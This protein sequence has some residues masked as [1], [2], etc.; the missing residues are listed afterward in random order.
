[1]LD[2]PKFVIVARFSNRTPMTALSDNQLSGVIRIGQLSQ[3]C[4]S[5]SQFAE[6]MTHEML[7]V[8]DSRSAVFLEFDHVDGL[9]ILGDSISYGLDNKHSIRYREHYHQLD[10]CFQEFERRQTDGRLPV[11]S[12]SQVIERQSDFINTEYYQDFLRPTKVHESLIFGLGDNQKLNGL[13]GLHRHPGEEA[14][15]IADRLMIQLV[16]PYLS[17]AILYR[18]REREIQRQN[19]LRELVLQSSNVC[20]YLLLNEDYVCLDVGGSIDA[21][22]D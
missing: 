22:F 20:G 9:P 4:L 16:T 7:Q 11:V 8:F 5:E 3:E 12:T 14:Y 2:P 19:A 18:Q 17:T 10:P 1:M 13:V 6:I 21:L 15:S